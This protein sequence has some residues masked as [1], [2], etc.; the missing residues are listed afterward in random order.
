MKRWCGPNLKEQ[1][2]KILLI[3]HRKSDRLKDAFVL[4]L[5]YSRLKHTMFSPV[6]VPSEFLIDLQNFFYF[7][8]VIIRILPS[9]SIFSID[10]KNSAK[11]VA[12]LSTPFF[13]QHAQHYC[14]WIISLV[15]RTA[16]SVLMWGTPH[17]YCGLPLKIISSLRF[18]WNIL[19]VGR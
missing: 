17:T 13:W 3:V 18:T 19:A 16:S 2:G 1:N 6:T 12:M 4:I 15:N 8:L 14:P 10:L 9:F 7:C 11:I 5:I